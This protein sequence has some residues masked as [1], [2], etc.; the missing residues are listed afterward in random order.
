M[1]IKIDKEGNLAKLEMMLSELLADS[2]V[3]SI[4]MLACDENFFTPYIVDPLLSRLNKPVFGGIFPQILTESETLTK[5]TILAGL[6]CEVSLF[7][8]K[9]ISHPLTNID[10]QMEIPFSGKPVINKTNFLFVD[11]MSTSIAKLLESSFNHFGL[12]SNY[13]GGGAGSMSFKPTP[14]IITPEGIL[15]DA[16]IFAFADMT[17]G[18]GVAHGWSPISGALKVTEACDNKVISLDWKPALEV[19]R[20]IV[21]KESGSA[22]FPFDFDKLAKKY[23]IGIVKMAD[24]LL[25]R[26]PVKTEDQSLVCLGELPLN[27]FVFVLNGDSASLLEGAR[28]SRSLAE[29]VFSSRK[30]SPNLS[31]T[32]VTFFIDCITRALFLGDQFNEELHIASGGGK[33]IGALS[34]GEIANS[35]S[36][37]LEFY[38]KTSVVGIVAD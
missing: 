25:V 4:M 37:Y 34:L 3:K 26:D 30:V 35:G 8:I 31:S 10:Q 29:S 24:E 14:C 33:L 18:V 9:N 23:P 13:I 11:G 12:K 2:S 19:Y 22:G 5:G 17:S 38:N 15:Q 21:V 16:A 36:D 20:D 27:S 7:V 1:I 32:S 28:R 6:T